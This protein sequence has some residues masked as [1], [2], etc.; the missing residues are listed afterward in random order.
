MVAVVSV[1]GLHHSDRPATG[2]TPLGGPSA[3]V[4]NMTKKLGHQSGWMVPE[5]SA[6][7]VCVGF[8]GADRVYNGG[9]PSLFPA[10]GKKRPRPLLE[11][12][13]ICAVAYRSERAV[14]Q[15]RTR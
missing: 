10:F 8:A 15:T 1:V 4:T 2:A 11:A 3:V 14:V 13:N 5:G 12:K 6:L 9:Q 7:T